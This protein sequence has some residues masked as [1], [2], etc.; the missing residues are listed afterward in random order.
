[1]H[2]IRPRFIDQISHTNCGPPSEVRKVHDSPY[3]VRHTSPVLL[4]LVCVH[5]FTPN[6]SVCVC[7]CVCVCV[8]ACVCVSELKNLTSKECDFAFHNYL[9]Y[10]NLLIHSHYGQRKVVLPVYAWWA[11]NFAH[12]VHNLQEL[13]HEWMNEQVQK[14]SFGIVIQV[15]L[16][17]VCEQPLQWFFQKA[18][19]DCFVLW[20]AVDSVLSWGDEE[21]ED[22]CVVAPQHASWFTER[23][24]RKRM[25]EKCELIDLTPCINCKHV[26]LK[27]SRAVAY[28]L[29]TA[30]IH[31]LP[32][33]S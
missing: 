5:D 28:Q 6:T 2:L 27:L 21:R 30:S 32:Q 19:L 13:E 20:D 3:N 31:E 15:S 7:V 1:M 4:L 9:L 10:M 23:G 25:N 11:T 12:I 16:I 8:R 17:S 18:Y 22:G 33:L 29:A 14:K 26:A 24:W